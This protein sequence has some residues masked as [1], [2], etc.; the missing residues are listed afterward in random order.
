MKNVA[1]ICKKKSQLTVWLCPV[2][3][4]K[5]LT[6]Q[7][8]ANFHYLNIVHIFVFMPLLAV[9]YM[10]G[11][12]M[13]SSNRIRN[14]SSL[15]KVLY[16]AQE[17]FRQASCFAETILKNGWHFKPWERRWTTYM[18][19]SAYT[20]ALV[21]SYTR[22]FIN[23]RGWPR[24]P[25]RIIKYNQEQKVLHK[26]IR[27]LRNEVYAHTDVEK[28][29]VRPININGQPSAIEMLPQMRFTKEET[30]MIIKMVRFAN[31]EISN[32]LSQLVDTISLES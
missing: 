3:N 9:E 16:V 13:T 32:H 30:E 10:L 11:S 8:I 14:D 5:A 6:I 29:N 28:R 25:R 27:D 24:I 7:F 20:T 1:C 2:R 23:S 21:V 18:K 12:Q 31:E 19:Q 4:S 26:K 22:P 17:D 15:Y